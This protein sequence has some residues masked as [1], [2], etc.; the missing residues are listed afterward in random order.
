[1]PVLWGASNNE[2]ISKEEQY[3]DKKSSGCTR[4]EEEGIIE[5]GEFYLLVACMYRMVLKVHTYYSEYKSEI[6]ALESETGEVMEH[7]SEVKKTPDIQKAWWNRLR[8]K[9]HK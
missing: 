7:K 3:R 9:G 1:M 5:K 6:G 8:M 2:N 4:R